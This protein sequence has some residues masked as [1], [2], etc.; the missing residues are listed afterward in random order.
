MRIQNCTLKTLSIKKH[1]FQR[2]R[3]AAAVARHQPLACHLGRPA[4]YEPG[5]A[6]YK[7]KM[8]TFLN[9]TSSKLNSILNDSA[10]STLPAHPRNSRNPIDSIESIESNKLPISVP[11]QLIFKTHHQRT[12]PIDKELLSIENS[13]SNSFKSGSNSE[14]DSTGSLDSNS[15]LDFDSDSQIFNS[16]SNHHKLQIQ[17]FTSQPST[18]SKFS[19]SSKSQNHPN[20]THINNNNNNN[21][22]N[23]ASKSN[24]YHHQEEN[25]PHQSNLFIPNFYKFNNNQNHSIAKIIKEKR[26][27]KNLNQS[28]SSL[29][30]PISNDLH[31]NHLDLLHSN[32]N[33]DQRRSHTKRNSKLN[34]L[35]SSS[36]ASSNSSHSSDQPLHQSSFNLI[37]NSDESNQM[38]HLNPSNLKQPNLNLLSSSSSHQSQFKQNYS[39]SSLKSLLNDVIM[40]PTTEEWWTLGQI[41]CKLSTKLNSPSTSK[42]F[43][44]LQVNQG[45]Q[46]D[47][48]EEDEDEEEEEEEEEDDDDDHQGQ[49]DDDEIGDES[50]NSGASSTDLC[51]TLPSNIQP[52]Y[53]STPSLTS[54]K[55]LSPLNHPFNQ[56]IPNQSI[57]HLDLSSFQSS[58]SNLEPIPGLIPNGVEPSTALTTLTSVKGIIHMPPISTPI[59]SNSLTVSSDNSNYF[60]SMPKLSAMSSHSLTRINHHTPPPITLLSDIL[61]KTSPT[62]PPRPCSLFHD[63]IVRKPIDPRS[64]SALTG[65]R[66][67]QSFIIHSSAGSGAYGIVKYAHE[68]GSDGQPIGPPLVIKSII[69]QKILAD[70][71]KRHK[72]LGPIP[73]EI[74]VLDHLR[75]VN[76]RPSIITMARKYIE[77]RENLGQLQSIP[78]RSELIQNFNIHLNHSSIQQ[79]SQQKT[80]HPNICGILDYFEDPDYYYLVMP[81]FGQGKDLFERIELAPDGLP[82]KEMK[83]II[84]QIVDAL[85]F[86]H[87]RNIAHRDLKDENV[88]LDNDGNAQLID[89]GSAAY[90]REGKKFETFSGTL[91][92]AAPEVLKGERHGGKE[93]DIWALGVM[94]Y[95]LVR[96]ECP[97]WNEE[98]ALSGLTKGTRARQSLDIKIES[99]E[100]SESLMDL[101]QQCL[102]L[103]PDKRP[104]I[105][106][107]CWHQYF[108]GKA[109]WKGNQDKIKV[110]ERQVDD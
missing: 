47:K 87:E 107:I 23:L 65:H 21:N 77:S 62:S 50:D 10:P 43:K 96:G 59:P 100:L 37:L 16:N 79:I 52:N 84:E 32:F 104:T 86:L 61:D 51:L 103:D 54:S 30:N 46:V 39:F 74:H 33:A 73:V 26:K 36:S 20:Q 38:T 11:D 9:S 90:V 35:S 92:F 83:K 66:S 72:V 57:S 53:A 2:R 108:I 75:R 56:P 109:G 69:K 60:Q 102:S 5:R 95:V 15:D 63:G 41:S 28:H 68:K 106:M 105:E 80:G 27:I 49:D 48:E 22:N 19:S 88:I 81:R 98:E 58:N 25:P 3:V 71:W 99:G 45:Q 4:G 78:S 93:V 76:Y 40:T 64:Y 55:L 7:F 67:L 17:K 34:R 18:P 85:A 42:D 70:C 31:A 14:S 89:F 12:S 44:T 82:A 110:D 6:A 97:F 101:L 94:M 8:K 13:Q 1:V 24:L 91:D 29:P